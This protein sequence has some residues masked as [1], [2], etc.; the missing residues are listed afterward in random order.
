MNGIWQKISLSA[1][2]NHFETSVKKLDGSDKES[3]LF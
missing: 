2:F 3:E 1:S